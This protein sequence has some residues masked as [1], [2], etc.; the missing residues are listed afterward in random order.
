MTT[1]QQR[2]KPTPADELRVL[3]ILRESDRPR[4]WSSIA[5]E[6]HGLRKATIEH[7]RGVRDACRSLEAKGLAREV[8]PDAAL[9]GRR[10]RRPRPG[11]G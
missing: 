5:C 10:P 9:R 4:V 8:P 2:F 11:G 3:A 1:Q 7:V 6:L